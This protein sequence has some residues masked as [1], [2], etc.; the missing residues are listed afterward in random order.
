MSG[1]V[2]VES[3]LPHAAPMILIDEM[4]RTG[5]TSAE[6]RVCITEDVM[7]YDAETGGVPSYVGIEYIAQTVAAHAGAA[8]RAN[9]DPVRVGF[10]LGTRHYAC[11]V[12]YFVLG[13]KLTVRVR[14]LYQAPHV[15]KFQGTIFL[16]GGPELASCA[17]S[18]YLRDGTEGEP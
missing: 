10:L 11:R 7:F 13:A 15:S 16:D 17:I 12:P 14:A 5:E 3:V 2:A 4:V 1:T 9:G 8:A 18:V 6:S